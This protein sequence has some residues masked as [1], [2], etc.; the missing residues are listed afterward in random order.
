MLAKA[1]REVSPRRQRLYW[2]RWQV[3]GSDRRSR[4]AP[5]S[6]ESNAAR[7]NQCHPAILRPEGLDPL[8]NVAVFDVASVDF[9]E[10]IER[11]RLV[12]GILER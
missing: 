11:G 8:R 5:I 12:A 10:I 3:R 6:L 7:W 2:V 1:K 9:E 4:N